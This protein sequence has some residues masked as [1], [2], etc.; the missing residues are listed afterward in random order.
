MLIIMK[1][2][3][4]QL[5]FQT[6][7][8]LKTLGRFDIFQIDPSK[9]GRNGFRHFNKLINIFAIYFNI[10]HIH[11]RKYFKEQTFP[12]HHGLACQ[13]ADISKPK[14]S[15]TIGHYGHQV[16]FGC[17]FIGVFQIILNGQAGICHTG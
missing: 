1:Y 2:R 6:R 8:N 4:I 15:G 10:K 11:I 14:N 17:I 12:L 5:F 13:G 9:S 7:F 3:N 16:S